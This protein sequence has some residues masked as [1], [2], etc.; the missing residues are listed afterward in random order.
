M[1]TSC[2]ST[3][4]WLELVTD[5][6]GGDEASGDG[7]SAGG[8]AVAV[9]G[10]G[11]GGGAGS[12]AGRGAG[13]AVAVAGGGASG[14]GVV[15]A[16][17]GRVP[18]EGGGGGGAPD[19]TGPGGGASGAD[20]AGGVAAAFGLSAVSAGCSTIGDGALVGIDPVDCHTITATSTTAAEPAPYIHC[21]MRRDRCGI[22]W[23]SDRGVIGWPA[24]ARADAS[25]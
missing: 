4:R 22:A 11:A 16:E 14:G 3:S 7:A 10:G 23:R 6:I 17:G 19:I 25:D 5:T 18:A 8:G 2:R 9:A 21:A 1:V 20:A 24:L 13:G 15:P 12:I